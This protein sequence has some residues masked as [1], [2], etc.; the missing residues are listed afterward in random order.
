MLN[1][2]KT[3][4]SETVGLSKDALHVHLGLVVFLAAVVVLRTTLG[5]WI[6][7]I[8]LLAFEVFNEVVDLLHEHDGV[9]ALD[10]LEAAKDI[11]NTMFWPTLVVVFAR[12]RSPGVE[13]RSARDET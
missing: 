4:L 8:V 10:F 2:F 13:A 11:V 3:A 9:R 7:W 6:P 12:H 5:N 1:S